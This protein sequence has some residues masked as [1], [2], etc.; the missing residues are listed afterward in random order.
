MNKIFTLIFSCLIGI[1]QISKAQVINFNTQVLGTGY[2]PNNSSGGITFLIEN[3]NPYPAV[4][5]TLSYFSSTAVTRDY[6]LWASSSS[7]SGLSF[8]PAL[9]LWSPVASVTGV[10]MAAG[11]QTMIFPFLTFNI[12]AFTSYR[13]YLTSSNVQYT[14][15][16]TFGGTTGCSPLTFSNAGVNFKNGEVLIGGQ[17]V[18]Y[19]GGNFTPRAFTGS[20][21]LTVL[22]TPCSGQP[23]AGTAT[24]APNNPCPG[25]NI[26]LN[27]TGSTAASGLAYQWQRA[28]T[29][30]GPWLTLPGATTVPYFYMPPPGSTTFYRCIVVCTF[31]GLNDTTVATTPAVVVQSWTPFSPCYCGSTVTATTLA[32]IGQFGMGTFN[33][34][35]ITPTPQT[36][37]PT[38]NGTYTNWM[39]LTPVPNFIQGLNYPIYAH[40]ITSAATLANTWVKV[41]IDY[42]HNANFT[43]AGEEIFSEA[44]LAANGFHPTN[45]H[46][47]PPTSLPGQTRMRVKMVT[48]GTS[49]MDPC[50]NGT[51]GEVE[52]YL[53]NITPAGPYD[54]TLTAIAAPVGNNCTDSTEIL[55][56]TV[57][58][59]GSS[60]INLLLNPYYV[61]YTIQTPSGILSFI[62][63]LNSGILPAFGSGCITVNDTINM[64]MG[65]NYVINAVVSCPTLTNNFLGNDSLA[66]AI[67][68]LNYRPVAADYQL[69]QFSSV[70]FGQGLGVS[71]CSSPLLDSVTITFAI[72]LCN[73]NIGSTGNGTSTGLPSNCSDQF[74]CN[75]GNAILP[76]LPPGASFTQPGILEITNL[77]ENALV[78]ATINTEMR[79]NIYTGSAPTGANLLSP[80]G[81]VATTL[82]AGAATNWTYKRNIPTAQLSSIFTTVAAG[83]ALK[84]GY[85]ESYQDNISMSD[86]DLNSPSGI[87]EATLKIYYQYVPPAFAWYDVPTAGTS[88]YSLSP[89]DPLSFTN[90]VVNNSNVPGNYTFYA[91]CLGLPNCRVPVDLIINPTPAAFQD[92]ISACEYAVGANYAIFILDTT[93]SASN[94]VTGGNLAASVQYFGD[95]ALTATTQIIDVNNDT[96]STNFI[97]SRVYYPLTG[98]AS[99]DS[100]LL[101][102]HSIPQFSLP[103][104]IGN[105][106]APNAI[107]ISSLISIFPTTNIDTLFFQ[108]AAYTIPFV[109][110]YSITLADS[111]YM[112]VNT[113]NGVVCSDSAIA[114]VQV[115][116]ATNNIA[117]QDLSFNFSIPGPIPCGNITLSDGNTETLYTTADCR[118]IATVTDAVDGVSLG[119]VNI[120]ED[121]A[122]GVPVH[123]GQPYIN[124]SYQIT[125]TTNDSAQVCLYF[126]DDDFAQ[127]S[128]TAISS[129]PSWPSL[130]PTSNLCISKVDNGDINTPGHTAVSIPNANITTTYDPLTT[131]WTVCFPVSS[132]SY[133]YC[134]TCNTPINAPLPINL[135]SF[136]GKRVNSKTE[137]N[138]VT[139]NEVN[140]SHFIVERS[141]DAKNFS[142]ISS[143][144]PTKA[145]GGNSTSHLNY[146]FTDAKP[147]EGHN[148]YRLTQVDIDGQQ[149]KSEIVD[150]YFGIEAQVTLYPNPASSE[151]NVEINSQ[152]NDKAHLKIMDAT[153]RVIRIVDL[154]LVVGN[155]M[156]QINLE[157]LSDGIYL[158]EITSNQGLHFTSSL[159]KK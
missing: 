19:G 48:G 117:N 100:V 29:P 149:S 24:A 2:T 44:S 57:C 88:L 43:D 105:A 96:S 153:G 79:M 118:K 123:N 133:F 18:G 73:D 82:P 151:L 113:N 94:V 127:Y 92:T 80:G 106:C 70:P 156:S 135:L 14:G 34:P 74:A 102:V 122:I 23:N 84:L 53:I 91:A 63:T 145:I 8:P 109:N 26:T 49:T 37:N 108:D 116:P 138:W 11:V 61:T 150:V 10:A 132:F 68:I 65:G 21:G 47:I 134:H 115:I 12:P 66:N 71:G 64:F 55:S 90:A 45:T 76:A 75:F 7:L 147:F 104:Y 131:V 136:T 154:V 9:P 120:C 119:A 77:K 139:S 39:T 114:D 33:N 1:T 126:L 15:I 27:L 40:Q 22:S 58:N 140:N 125:P 20:V 25:T 98:C 141:K 152:V 46:T 129:S 60:P 110:P 16:G 148:Y 35:A 142:N 28:S 81:T 42:N 89:F 32:D 50:T 4:L 36:S 101:D 51:T 111:L 158:V 41:W 72:G 30:S 54:P 78:P 112:I 121:I 86:I 52:D 87:T 93:Q 6:T 107:D 97:Y 62:D 137:L 31:S 17:N 143:K 130:V 124:R 157:S 144:I 155:N 85:W 69:C 56:A 99:S 5:N 128:A 38:A 13:F 95:Q 83:G 146:D 3:T 67:N 59:Y 103:I 159:R